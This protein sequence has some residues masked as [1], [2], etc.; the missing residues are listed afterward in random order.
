VLAMATV[1]PDQPEQLISGED[2]KHEVGFLGLLWASEG[3]IIG[4]GWLFSAL[5][6]LTI[7][8]PGALVAWVIASIIVIVIALVYA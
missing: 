1:I 3:S 4:S 5:L 6:A 2:L 7:A 8:G